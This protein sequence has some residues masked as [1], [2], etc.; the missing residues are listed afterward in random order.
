VNKLN[1]TGELYRVAL[2]L[3]F[4]MLGSPNYKTG[5]YNGTDKDK[6]EDHAVYGS[7][8]IMQLFTAYFDSEL[9]PWTP[10]AFTGR[11]DYGP[12][13]GSGPLCARKNVLFLKTR[14]CDSRRIA[15]PH[16]PLRR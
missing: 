14:R 10:S 3:N 8:Y 15:R 16:Q 12:F 11:S 1:A 5:V 9:F 7:S 4:D 13:L 6:Q 2:N